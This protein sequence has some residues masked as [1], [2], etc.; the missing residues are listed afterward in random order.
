LEE[1][2]K[3]TGRRMTE[4]GRSLNA[5]F[6]RGNG[7]NATTSLH[8]PKKEEK[9]Q[10]ANGE[11][12]GDLQKQYPILKSVV[13]GTPHEK[14]FCLQETNLAEKKKKRTMKFLCAAKKLTIETE[15]KKKKKGTANFHRASGKGPGN[16]KGGV[17]EAEKIKR[18]RQ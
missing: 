7:N 12:N 6:G 14:M 8:E 2:S 15:K 16:C 18:R 3:K 17:T 9:P 11:W 1:E 13:W 10:A 5:S 4:S